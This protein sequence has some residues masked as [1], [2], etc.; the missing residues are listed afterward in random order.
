MKHMTQK[1]KDRV[2]HFLRTIPVTRDDDNKLCA[3]I[4][5]AEFK[6][7]GHDPEQVPAVELFRMMKRGQLT[8]PESIMRVRRKL[9][10][11]NENLRGK[12]YGVRHDNQEAVK[13]F[14][15]YRRNPK[16]PSGEPDWVIDKRKAAAN[17]DTTTPE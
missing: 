9:Q 3:V 16:W 13:E 1:T 10:E 2:R 7:A 14:L 5:H 6:G 11:E 8:S 12:L 17:D 4:W 15:G